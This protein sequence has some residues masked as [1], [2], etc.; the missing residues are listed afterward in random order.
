LCNYAKL[1]THSQTNI[2]M[3]KNLLILFSAGLVIALCSTTLSV[4]SSSSGAPSGKANDPASGSANCTD[5]HSGIATNATAA[6]ASITSTIPAAGYTPGST[7]TI[8]ATVN[9]TGRSKF[10][11]QISPQNATGALLGTLIN[12]STQTKLVGISKYVTHTTSGNSG[13]N[14]KSWTFDWTAPAAGTGVVTFYGSFMAANGDGGTSG[15]IVYK[16]SYAVSEAVASGINE[17]EANTNALTVI[18]LKNALQISYNA[19]SAATANVELYTL[20]GT[21]VS[22]TSYEQQNAGTVNLNVDVKDGLNTGIYIIK[23]QQGTQV[24]TKKLALVF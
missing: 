19:Q 13:S 5:C 4:N 8:T 16:T 24:L 23:V 15:D 7:Y 18:N 2:I 21:I 14:T 22:T 9:F 20:N 10:G 1:K 12:T 6:Q 17:V 3:K 11:F